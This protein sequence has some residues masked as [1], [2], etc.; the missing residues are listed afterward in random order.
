M[1]PSLANAPG[2][3]HRRKLTHYPF[4]SSL[5]YAVR[6]TGFK[7]LAFGSIHSRIQERGLCPNSCTCNSTALSRAGESSLPQQ[8]REPQKPQPQS[9]AAAQTAPVPIDVTNNAAID[10]LLNGRHTDPFALLGPHPVPGGWVIRF[11]I[12]WAAEASIAIGG[13]SAPGGPG[14][15]IIKARDSVKSR[16]EG[17]FE[18]LW[19]SNQSAP[20]APGSYK[21]QGRTHHG[22]AF[23]MYDAYSFPYLLSEFDLYFMGEGV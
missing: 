20:P 22:E 18:A 11:F 12:P 2:L 7:R 17:F 10:A 6:T 21:T 23:E 16:P 5:A 1:K 15:N 13:N 3:H 19:P 14:L 4:K 9:G 8:P